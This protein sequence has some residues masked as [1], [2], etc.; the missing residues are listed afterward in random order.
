MVSYS[1]TDGGLLVPSEFTRKAPALPTVAV[2]EM[3]PMAY[4]GQTSQSGFENSIYD[5]GKF[6]GG[7]GRTQILD[8]DYWT[9][10]A[11]S[12]ELFTSNHYA[13]GLIRRLVTNEINTGINPEANPDALTLG[14]TDDEAQEWTEG[15]EN[16]YGLWARTPKLCDFYG[17]DTFAAITR[18]RRLMELVDGDVL[19]VLR[20]GAHTRLPTVQLVSG[21]SVRTPFGDEAGKIKKENT[22]THGVEQ[23][24]AKRVVAYWVR[25]EDGSFERIPTHG[26]RSGRRIAWL[27]YGT[28]RRLDDLRGQ[29][30]LAIVLQSLKEIDRYRDSTQRKAVIN[31]ILAMFIRKDQ[32]KIG[33]LPISGA[34]TRKD[35]VAITDPDGQKRNYGITRHHPG[36]VL[37]ELQV[38]EEPVAF[39][40]QGTDQA[41]G[42]FEQAV[43][44]SIAWAQEIPPEILSLAFSNN[45]SASQAAINEFKIYLNLRWGV[46]GETFCGPIYVEWLTSE[47]LLRKIEAPGF[48]ESFRSATNYDVYAAWIRCDWYG[49]IKPST[50]MLKQAKGS[51]LLVRNG[52]STNAREARITTG[53][54]YSHNVAKL[55]RENEQLAEALRPLVEMRQEVQAANSEGSATDDRVS[56]AGDKMLEYIESEIDARLGA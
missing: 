18:K 11:R 52:W 30:L 7:Y 48:L 25:Q 31:S 53:T 51:E 15:V 13:R 43:L 26:A 37:E 56:A 50:D 39:G 45:Y 44:A 55:K 24:K 36:M 17:V 34:A 22:V 4:A 21:A 10:R 29:P 27:T 14:L 3:R 35:N 16:R 23:D 9:L 33:S 42:V 6:A 46:E 8:V 5:G 28:D 1:K 2:D 40:S 49:S 54:K 47:A 41:F 12:N 32:E 38:G 19:V 20:T